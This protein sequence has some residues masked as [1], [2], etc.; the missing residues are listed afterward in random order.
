MAAKFTTSHYIELANL[1]GEN[2]PPADAGPELVVHWLHIL[3]DFKRLFERDNPRF[4]P[5]TFRNALEKAAKERREALDK[6]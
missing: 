2:E 3:T 5:E 4:N 1:L 6:L